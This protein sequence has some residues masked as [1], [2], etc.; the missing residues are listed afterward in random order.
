MKDVLQGILNRLVPEKRELFNS[1]KDG[2]LVKELYVI[3]LRKKCLVVLDDVW[4]M[5]LWDSIGSAFPRGEHGSKILLTTRN[6]DIALH[7]DPTCFVHQP[8]FL[9]EDESWELLQKKVLHKLNGS[10]GRSRADIRGTGVQRRYEDGEVSGQSWVRGGGRL[11]GGFVGDFKL[12][13]DM[14]MLGREMVRQCGGLPLAIN[15]LGGLLVTKPT[16]WEWKMVQ[17]NISSYLRRG[18]SLEKHGKVYEVLDLSYRDL[19]Y[20]LKPCFLFLGNF[21]ED[22]NI[23]VRKLYQMW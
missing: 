21:P 9:G 11:G 15:V 22:S 19:P 5:D 4:S 17:E 13:M 7:V 3:Q 18:R 12:D 14:E 20:Q 6:Q 23:R 8:R 16:L 10:G 1:M 2:E